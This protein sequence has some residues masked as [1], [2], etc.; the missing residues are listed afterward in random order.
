MTIKKLPEVIFKQ[1]P[2]E[3]E[4]E[5]ILEFLD[6]NWSGKITKKFPEFLKISKIS[7]K[8]E[9]KK[10]I[11]NLIV[12]IRE[13]LKEKMSRGLKVIKFDWQ[14]MEKNCLEKLSEIIQTNWL[15][16]EI[17]AY[18]SINPICPRFLDTW[19]F[20]VSPDNKNSNIIIA[21]EI[22]HFLYFKKLKEVFPKIKKDKYEFPNKEWLLSELVT[23]IILNDPRMQK[24]LGV[25][26]GYYREHK[27][28]KI[29][30]EL[31]T[32][33]IEDLYKNFVI[34]KKDFSS[35]I[36]KSSKIINKVRL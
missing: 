7:D 9:K 25:K 36:K 20:S 27:N 11:K 8:R 34:E 28:L 35:F 24:I 12:Q 1:M 21:H 30:N 18:I 13:K 19:S 3:L 2:I 16:K 14:K 32:R 31:A 23:P 17:T 15:E 6:T 5:M 33:V 10:A 22:S 4:S 26:D 29:G